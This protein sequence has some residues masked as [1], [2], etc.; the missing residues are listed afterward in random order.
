LDPIAFNERIERLNDRHLYIRDCVARGRGDQFHGVLD[1]LKPSAV[2]V[3]QTALR[4]GFGK[5]RMIE[6]GQPHQHL[7]AMLANKRPGLVNRRVNIRQAQCSEWL[8]RRRNRERIQRREHMSALYQP[9]ARRG[10]KRRKRVQSLA[11]NLVRNRP[12]IAARS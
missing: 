5:P 6:P 12:H 9:P 7:A 2:L 1:C 11:P 10:R 8:Y 3:S 4:E